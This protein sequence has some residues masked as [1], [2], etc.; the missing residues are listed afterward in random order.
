MQRRHRRCARIAAAALAFALLGAAG[1]TADP[2]PL[3]PTPAED[4]GDLSHDLTACRRAV[5][6]ARAAAACSRLIESGQN[7]PLAL[8]GLHIRRARAYMAMRDTVRAFADFDEAVRLAPRGT[9]AYTAR[10]YA[11]LRLGAHDLAIADLD[12]AGQHDRRDSDILNGRCWARAIASVELDAARRLCNRALALRP[13]NPAFLDSRGLVELKSQR[14]DRAFADYDA[15]FRWDPES[16]HT[17][18]GRG[19]AAIGLGRRAEGETDIARALA[20]DAGVGEC[21]RRY[22]VSPDLL[23]PAPPRQQIERM[24]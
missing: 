14:F 3:T 9:K 10:G 7:S 12:R 24:P 1:A 19:L 4:V 2:L 11:H 22:G 20:M 17:L 13:D 23:P 21:Y 16:A 8:S 5:W 18:F 6:A 15:S